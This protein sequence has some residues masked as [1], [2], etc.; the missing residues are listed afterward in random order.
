MKVEKHVKSDFLKAFSGPN[1]I[2]GD[3]DA[4]LWLV[5]RTRI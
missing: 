2:A 3:V 4:S 5:L 1:M